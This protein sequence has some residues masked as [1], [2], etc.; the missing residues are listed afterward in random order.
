MLVF[1]VTLA[2]SLFVNPQ[3]TGS[4]WAVVGLVHFLVLFM[5][6]RR[7]AASRALT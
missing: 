4:D 3:G 2:V 5:I 6:V 7:S 1:S